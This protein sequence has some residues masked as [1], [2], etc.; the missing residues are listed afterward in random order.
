MA[1]PTSSS[2]RLVLRAGLALGALLDSLLVLSTLA[3]LCGLEL[4][5]LMPAAG[6]SYPWLLW[7]ALLGR[8]GVQALA[9][10]DRRR[11]DLTIPWLASTLLVSGLAALAQSSPAPVLA[12]AYGVVGGLQLVAWERTRG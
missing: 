9:C 5:D 1:S 3:A 4:G 6:L 11:Y 8:A 2:L 10:Y 7:P 12:I